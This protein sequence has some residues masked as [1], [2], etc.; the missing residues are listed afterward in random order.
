[1]TRHFAGRVS[2]RIVFNILLHTALGMKT[3]S[4]VM[5]H[6]ATR[7]AREPN[8]SNVTTTVLQSCQIYFHERDLKRL[9]LTLR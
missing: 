9:L 4:A 1:M 3:R 6:E 5:K 7:S 8:Q 2:V